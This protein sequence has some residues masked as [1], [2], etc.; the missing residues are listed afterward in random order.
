M[1][2]NP[3]PRESCKLF[4]HDV[5]WMVPNFKTIYLSVQEGEDL[6]LASE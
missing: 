4:V 5:V 2:P 6:V 3:I 1:N